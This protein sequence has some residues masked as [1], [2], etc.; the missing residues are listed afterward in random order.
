MRELLEV[1]ERNAFVFS[2]EKSKTLTKTP[3]SSSSPYIRR[4]ASVDTIY[5]LGQWQRDA[6]YLSYC[7]RLM[8]DRATQTPEEFEEA[9][10][11]MPQKKCSAASNET[12]E[13]KV[14]SIFMHSSHF[15]T[16]GLDFFLHPL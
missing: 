4:T 1:T 12:L 13:M 15:F 2:A 9:D 3:V 7:G 5:L 8:M 16:Y 14:S 11:R 6:L 10:R